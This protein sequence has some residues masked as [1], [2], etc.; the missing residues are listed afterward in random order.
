MSPIIS[1]EAEKIR[2]LWLEPLVATADMLEAHGLDVSDAHRQN[3]LLA[4]IAA[5]LADISARLEPGNLI[6]N[7]HVVEMPMVFHRED[8]I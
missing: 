7:V 2:K 4:E 5:Q 3:I 8:A 6:A 1:S